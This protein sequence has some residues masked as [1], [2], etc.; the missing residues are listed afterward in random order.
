MVHSA[1]SCKISRHSYSAAAQIY[2]FSPNPSILPPYFII[3]STDIG[4]WFV[5][6]GARCT[7]IPCSTVRTGLHGH[8]V[9][10]AVL[11]YDG[12]TGGDADAEEGVVVEDGVVGTHLT[13]TLGE[14]EHSLAVVTATGEET[15]LTAD[16]GYVD[17]EGDV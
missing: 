15:Q 14:L 12:G 13:K 10:R 6:R 5:R 1:L 11:P 17:I 2:H 16:I 4:R 7:A 8:S 3:Q 9:H